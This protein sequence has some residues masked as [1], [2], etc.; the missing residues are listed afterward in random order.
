MINIV[1]NK[2]NNDNNDH[3]D[4]RIIGLDVVIW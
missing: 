3:V 1:K 2:V 4:N